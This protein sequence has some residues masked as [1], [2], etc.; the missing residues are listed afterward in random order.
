MIP[1]ENSIFLSLAVSAVVVDR[2]ERLKEGFHIRH[3]A[4]IIGMLLTSL[5]L[6]GA[7]L[8]PMMA[9]IFFF[10]RDRKALM[11]VT[12]LIGS[13]LAVYLLMGLSGSN[14][15]YTFQLLGQKLHTQYLQAFAL[16][17]I[18]L[19]NEKPGP[20]TWFSKWFFYLFYPLHIW[21]LYLISVLV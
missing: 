13:F 2:L 9:V 6:E 19:Y 21:V 4:L 18:L 3:M 15:Y 7:F 16:I 17:P 12:Y 20:R 14:P 10:L 8:L 1:L 11:S 5:L